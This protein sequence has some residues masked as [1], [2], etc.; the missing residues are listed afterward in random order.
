VIQPVLAPRDGRVWQDRPWSSG[1]PARLAPWAVLVLAPI[2]IAAALRL[3]L[4]NQLNFADA[5]FY[6]GYAFTPNHHFDIFGFNYFAVRFPAILAIGVFERMFGVGDGYVVLRFLLAVACGISIYACVGRFASRSVALS[7][8]LLLYLDPFFSRMLLWDYSGF[9]E[10]AAAVIG[11]TLWY[12]SSDRRLWLTAL[13]GAALAAA[14]FANA[15]IGTAILVLFVLEAAN[16][17]RQGRG[18]FVH[19]LARVGVVIVAG[20]AVFIVGW[21][22]YLAILGSLSPF[23]LLR[24]T[25]KFFGQNS[26]ES[27]PYQFPVSSWIWKEPRIWAPVIVSI[28]LLATLRRRIL[29]TDVPA[30]IAQFCIAYT[31]FL[32]VYRFAIT[33]SVIETWYAYDITVVATAPALGVLLAQSRGDRSALARRAV[34]FVVV[35]AVSALIIRDVSGPI[36]SLY[37]DIQTHAVLDLLVLAIG[38]LAALLCGARRT[39]WP[40][41][42]LLS[43]VF[44]VMTFAPSV[45]D[46]RGTTGIFVTSG[47]QEWDAYR[48]DQ[49]FQDIVSSYDTTGGRVFLWW[50]GTL[51]DVDVTWSELPQTGNTLNELGVN[52][53]L[54][55]LTPLGLA[56]LSTLPVKYV[57]ILAPRSDEVTRGI[58]SLVKA[59]VK[60]SVI[61]RGRLPSDILSYALYRRAGT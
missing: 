38:L 27:A 36:A 11:V 24:P 53:P 18:Q 21:L 6:T 17:L 7:G 26:Q 30:R 2:V 44:A 35:F 16:A 52:Q 49:R 41:L 61:L 37:R 34:A 42:M 51:G 25:I 43:A 12:W 8:A 60:G 13:S 15:L 28:A 29:G 47:T 32:W 23:D 14:V 55:A 50:P 22:A 1:L 40:A 59:G 10:V 20:I 19:F 58:A 33:S 57:M 56:R 5:W 31:A 45:L 9:M 46:G 54:S 48:A 4:I 3:P 39:A